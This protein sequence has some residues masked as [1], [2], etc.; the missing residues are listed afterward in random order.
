MRCGCRT[1][2]A[3]VLFVDNNTTS[4]AHARRRHSAW[5]SKSAIVSVAVASVSARARAHTQTHIFAVHSRAV[6]PTP[7]ARPPPS[8]PCAHCQHWHWRTTTPCG[9]GPLSPP[10]MPLTLYA[11][12]SVQRYIC[13]ARC[14]GFGLDIHNNVRLSIVIYRAWI[15]RLPD[16]SAGWAMCHVPSPSL[17]S[18]DPAQ[19]RTTAVIIK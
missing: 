17:V 19:H 2:C 15:G 18:G 11:S 10:P 13:C 16:A 1:T 5:R 8:V 9:T 3:H 12:R 14:G 4:T 6:C 7:G